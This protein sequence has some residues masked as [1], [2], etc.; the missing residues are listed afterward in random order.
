MT[1]EVLIEKLKSA[2]DLDN[3]VVINTPQGEFAITDV[4]AHYPKDQ[5]PVTIDICPI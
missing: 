3:E 5:Q 1:V 2:Y 4:I